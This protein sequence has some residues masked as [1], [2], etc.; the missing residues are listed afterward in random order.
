MMENREDQDRETYI[1]TET[2]ETNE[3][4]SA[5]PQFSGGRRSRK[6]HAMAKKVTTLLLTGVLFGTAAGGTM[7]GVNVAAGRMAAGGNPAAQSTQAASDA[8]ASGTQIATAVPMS[9]SSSGSATVA[10]VVSNAMPT[11]VAI[12]IKGTETIQSFFGTQKA[13]VSGAG[14]GIIIGKND[15]ELLIVTNNHVVASSDSIQVT[16]TDGEKVDAAVKGTDS[17]KDLA[18]VAVQLK[19]IK[20]STMGAIKIATLGDSDKLQLGQG[21]IA[22]GN[23]LGEGQSVT[24]GIVSMLNKEIK[25]ED[26][27]SRTLIQV[28]AAINPGNS[29]GALL[30]MS[31][32]VIGINS[33]KYATTAVEG[34]GFAIPISQV[35]E[36]IQNL[37]EQKTKIA[38]A[39]DEQGY[40]GIQMQNID[41]AMSQAYGIPEGVYV[42]KILDGTAAAGSELRERDVITEI[43]GT[44]V[45]TGEDLHKQ[46]SYYKTGDTVT[47]TVQTLDDGSYKERKIE[48]RLGSREDADKM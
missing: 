14:S 11:V 47:L 38:V 9:S 17:S 10:D 35:K 28:D 6:S 45:S 29:G 7:F 32:N 36:L 34:M 44:K 12:N 23:A 3:S 31:G 13:E 43:N 40:L 8:N 5:A 21:V 2:V 1:D 16:F 39:A 22:I 20:D 26:G 48:V 15:S 4:E 42:Y 19:D 41:S 18:V 46:M 25:D 24:T 27:T 33:A 37:S 30:D